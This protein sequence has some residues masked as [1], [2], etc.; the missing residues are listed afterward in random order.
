MLRVCTL[1]TDLTILTTVRGPGRCQGVTAKLIRRHKHKWYLAEE[2]LRMDPGVW[3][4]I[5][6]QV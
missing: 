2:R 6:Y 5:L 4:M 1:R 3:E